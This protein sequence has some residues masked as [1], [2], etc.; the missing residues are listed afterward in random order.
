MNHT[1]FSGLPP[2]QVLRFDLS[3][4]RLFFVL[5]FFLLFCTELLKQ[6]VWNYQMKMNREGKLKYIYI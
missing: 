3:F 6:R 4:S 5:F 2:L 1:I